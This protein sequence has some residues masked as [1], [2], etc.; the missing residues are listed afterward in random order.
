MLN[1]NDNDNDKNKDNDNDNDNGVWCPKE[2]LK[3]I[4]LGDE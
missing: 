3:E 4:R 1:D 2:L